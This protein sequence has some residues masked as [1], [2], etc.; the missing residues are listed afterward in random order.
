M[1]EMIEYLN[2]RDDACYHDCSDCPYAAECAT[3]ED[4]EIPY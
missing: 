2:K 4:P 3:E 1:C